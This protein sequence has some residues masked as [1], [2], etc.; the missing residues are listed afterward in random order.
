MCWRRPGVRWIQGQSQYFIDF[1]H[2]INTDYKDVK[3]DD[4]DEAERCLQ[5]V[6]VKVKNC[7]SEK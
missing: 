5:V 2:E 1:P 3:A 6:A 7:V 4:A